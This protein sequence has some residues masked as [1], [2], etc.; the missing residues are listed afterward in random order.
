[1]KIALL[2]CGYLRG[3]EENIN[4]I[5]ENIIQDHDVDIYMH[6]TACENNDKY[7]NDNND[8]FF[9][10][11][12]L[13][14]K[15]LI[16][17]DNF[18]FSDN[19]QMNN[20][21][22]Q[23]YKIYWLNEERK[24]VAAIESICYDVIIK[25]RPDI[26]I[27]TKISYSITENTLYLPNS[28]KIDKGKLLHDTD[29]YICDI[30]AYG[31]ENSMNYYCDYYLHIKEYIKKYGKINETLLFYYLENIKTIL[32][33]I[34]Y[35]V[36]LSNCNVIGITG[37]SG[38][39]KSTISDI[40][41]NIFKESFLLEC[42][43]YHKWER[44]D[45][46]WEKYTH[47]NP[48]A[49]YLTKMQEDTFNLKIGNSI[50]QVN[51]NH[52]CGKFTDHEYIESKNNLIVCGLHTL[53]MPK[54]IINYKIFMDT[55]DNLRIPWKIIRDMKKRNYSKEKIFEQINNRLDD[56][57]K[58]ILPQKELADIIINMNTNKI[59]D[60]DCTDLTS[61]NPKIL[62]RIAYHKKY[63]VNMTLL[64]PYVIS[65]EHM[66]NFI[67]LTINSMDNYADVII[68]IIKTLL[69]I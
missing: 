5:Y 32:C 35:Y 58:Y 67:Y 3:F 56:Y 42:D 44:G 40:V 62:L 68:I 34:D 6:Y 14:P 55:N 29:P 8:I 50:Y 49:N 65:I 27:V 25:I 21:L 45:K 10:K 36:I 61:F 57:N 2:I 20:L 54:T 22:N 7:N 24:K 33:D 18:K 19:E 31:D 47:L 38:S 63:T 26:H 28:S 23:N 1:M 16:A 15:L 43:R 13:K 41:K 37:D 51:Y 39:G 9:I 11:N 59:F 17:S 69:P 4:S 64:E 46:N 53:Y 52:T 48:D 66:D 30:L 12:K 60:I